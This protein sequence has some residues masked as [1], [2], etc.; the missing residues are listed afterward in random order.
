MTIINIAAIFA[1]FT[2]PKIPPNT[3]IFQRH[4]ARNDDKRFHFSSEYTLKYVVPLIGLNILTLAKEQLILPDD[5]VIH[6]KSRGT[7]RL[8]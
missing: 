6:S 7:M 5:A 2:S 3:S 8:W 1:F 4:M